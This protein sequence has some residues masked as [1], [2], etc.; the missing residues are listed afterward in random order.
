MGAAQHLEGLLQCWEDF[1]LLQSSAITF[2]L[3][4]RLPPPGPLIGA[5]RNWREF[6]KGVLNRAPFDDA[7]FGVPSDLVDKL[8]LFRAVPFMVHAWSAS[9][10]R[11]FK[12]TRELQALL[13]ATSVRRMTYE[14]LMPTMPFPSF[15]IELEKPIVDDTDGNVVEAILVISGE[16]VDA[17]DGSAKGFFRVITLPGKV[18]A[19]PLP[20][21][22]RRQLISLATRG[23][24]DK[25]GKAVDRAG[26]GFVI[27]GMA[28]FGFALEDARGMSITTSLGKILGPCKSCKELHCGHDEFM[29]KIVHIIAGMCFYLQSLPAGS[30]HKSAWQTPPQAR[31]SK[32][33]RAVTDENSI[34]EVASS[35]A[36]AP[37]ELEMLERQ[38]MQDEDEEGSKGPGGEIRSGFR[39]G[40][41]RRKPGF[42]QDPDAP[43]TVRVRWTMV[44]ENKLAPGTIPIGVSSKVCT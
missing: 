40:H 28:G 14:D 18:K 42:G 10:R 16:E 9:S 34:C 25:L 12:I 36:I 8:G 5:F 17:K 21:Y 30:P 22:D 41:W 27:P 38:S 24:W 26:E 20:D 3:K 7:K 39:R 35:Q 37:E 29:L 33:L 43:K 2:H 32:N 6:R 4:K 13:L 44:N 1:C 19:K 11:V 31:G 15:L 23:Q